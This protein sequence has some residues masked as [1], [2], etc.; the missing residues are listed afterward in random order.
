MEE[1]VNGSLFFRLRLQYVPSRC[2]LSPCLDNIKN[3]LLIDIKHIFMI[4]KLYMC[5]KVANAIKQC[6]I[7]F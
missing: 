2:L 1:G 3:L 5:N 7:H 6:S 4:H